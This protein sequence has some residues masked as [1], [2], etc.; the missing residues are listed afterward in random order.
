VIQIK[1]YNMWLISILNLA[2]LLGFFYGMCC[3]KGVFMRY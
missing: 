3:S 2:L 1:Q